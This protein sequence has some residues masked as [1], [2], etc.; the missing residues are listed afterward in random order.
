MCAIAGFWAA[1]IR[2]GMIGTGQHLLIL[3][4]YYGKPL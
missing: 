3:F 1:Q 4:I 2:D